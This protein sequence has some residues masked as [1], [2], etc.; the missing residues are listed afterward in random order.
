MLWSINIGTVAG[1]VV[2]LHVTFLLFLGW[3]FLASM[4][5]AA[6]E[7]AGLFALWIVQFFFPSLRHTMIWVY[8]GWIGVELLLV[9][10][11]RKRIRAFGAFARSWK[12]KR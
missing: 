4:D 7:A 3:I 2:R 1:T 5:L 10:L 12:G 8:G 6:Y 9:A 11:G